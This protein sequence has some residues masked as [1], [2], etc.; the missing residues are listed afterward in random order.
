M[1][2]EVSVSSDV[3]GENEV[4]RGKRKDV[5]RVERFGVGGAEC[6]KG[7]R[8]CN[9]DDPSE[10]FGI[11]SDGDAEGENGDQDVSEVS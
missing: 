6:S 3:G 7:S 1:V 9:H 2:S 4:C 11:G 10:V 5:V 8:A